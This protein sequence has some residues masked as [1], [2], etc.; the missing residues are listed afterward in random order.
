VLKNISVYKN[1]KGEVVSYLLADILK[2]GEHC[3]EDETVSFWDEDKG[4][5]IFGF[6]IPKEVRDISRNI[7]PRFIKENTVILCLFS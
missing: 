2:N 4:S 3:R 7:S 6:N 5:Y 1:A